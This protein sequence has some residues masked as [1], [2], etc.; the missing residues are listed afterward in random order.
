[1]RPYIA[2]AV[3]GPLTVTEIQKCLRYRSRSGGKDSHKHLTTGGIVTRVKRDLMDPN[4]RVQS[5]W[6]FALNERYEFAAEVRALLLKMAQRW[7]PVELVPT[8]KG[9]FPQ[10]TEPTA[11]HPFT[12]IGLRMLRVLQ[13]TGPISTASLFRY[14]GKDT[15][16]GW[17]SL[18]T[19]RGKGIITVQVPKAYGAYQ[20][21]FN[22]F[23]VGEWELRKLLEAM[24]LKRPLRP[25]SHLESAK[26]KARTR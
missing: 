24:I 22:S 19:L 25:F 5:T 16:H 13:S 1:M 4:K 12:N 21:A 3:Y 23:F 15:A 2:L 9:R 17:N 10:P 7:P 11:K 26:V 14:S 18:R 20:V 8:F 6:V